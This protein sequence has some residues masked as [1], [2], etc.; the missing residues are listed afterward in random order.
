[1]GKIVY[2]GIPY[3][4]FVQFAIYIYIYRYRPPLCFFLWG[5]GGGGGVGCEV[6]P[7]KTIEQGCESRVASA[8]EKRWTP[9]FWGWEYVAN[10]GPERSPML[11]VLSKQTGFSDGKP[12]I[13]WLKQLWLGQD[14]L[15]WGRL[16]VF[17]RGCG[18]RGSRLSDFRRVQPR[19]RCAP[20]PEAVAA[21][22][23][24]QISE[25][26]SLEADAP[27]PP[28]TIASK[29]Q[30]QQTNAKHRRKRKRKQ[31]RSHV[32]FFSCS[33]GAEGGGRGGRVLEGSGGKVARHRFWSHVRF[34]PRMPA[35]GRCEKTVR[36][37]GPKTCSSW[38][39]SLVP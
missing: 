9:C 23:A 6:G 15:E 2:L 20:P 25:G 28:N 26:S 5:G 3:F 10:S 11:V 32:V 21:V 16:D 18:S 39:T 4:R 17:H 22:A 24:F 30:P 37:V 29:A 14:I 36:Q 34:G 8:P 31:A 7:R 19:G 33:G 35:E 13:S 38:T 1:M 12:T 27:L